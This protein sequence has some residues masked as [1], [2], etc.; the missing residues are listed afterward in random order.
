MRKAPSVSRSPLTEMWAS[1]TEKFVVGI[2]DV[3]R[4]LNRP[5]RPH[6]RDN[7][8]KAEAFPTIACG[9]PLR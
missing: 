5:M 8:A 4:R 1:K 9:P 7:P 3:S 2:G 6:C